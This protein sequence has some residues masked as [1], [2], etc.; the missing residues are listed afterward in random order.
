MTDEEKA[1]GIAEPLDYALT[2]GQRR[3]LWARIAA[4][5][6]AE[7]EAAWHEGFKA[8]ED[9]RYPRLEH[10]INNLRRRLVNERALTIVLQRKRGEI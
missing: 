2:L 6:K 5:L 4:A 9:A 1:R 7:R 8:A 3:A 10:E